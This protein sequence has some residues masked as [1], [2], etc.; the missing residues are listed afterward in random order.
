[1]LLVGVVSIFSSEKRSWKSA[2]GTLSP[3]ITLS[4][5]NTQEDEDLLSENAS[6]N[7]EI[8]ANLSLFSIET[9]NLITSFVPIPATQIGKITN[10]NKLII[11]KSWKDV[12]FK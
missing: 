4:P 8:E 6:I 1:M 12:P 3:T 2:T 11:D 5:V 7:D 9:A 10:F